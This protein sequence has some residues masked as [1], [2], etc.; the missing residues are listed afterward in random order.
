MKALEVFKVDYLVNAGIKSCSLDQ[1]AKHNE[2]DEQEGQ[3]LNN[4]DF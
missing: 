1:I 2:T 3:T 4:D